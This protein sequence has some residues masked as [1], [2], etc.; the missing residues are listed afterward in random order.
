MLDVD[1]RLVSTTEVEQ[2]MVVAT[3]VAH[4]H[5]DLAVIDLASV[6]APLALHAD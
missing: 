1:A 4:E 3:D 6:A 5:A 2:G